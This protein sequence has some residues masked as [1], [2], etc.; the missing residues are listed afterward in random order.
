MFMRDDKTR[1]WNFYGLA[2]GLF[3]LG[4]LTKTVTAT[5]PAAMGEYQAT[6]KDVEP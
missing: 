2:F 1:R 6:H 4:L 5:L 3:L